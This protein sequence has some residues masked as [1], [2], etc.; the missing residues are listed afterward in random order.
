ML[1]RT[2]LDSDYDLANGTYKFVLVSGG[3]WLDYAF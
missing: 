3:A 1:R 2:V